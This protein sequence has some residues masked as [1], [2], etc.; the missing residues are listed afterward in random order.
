MLDST[1]VIPTEPWPRA[2]DIECRTARA[3]K[4]ARRRPEGALADPGDRRGES[5]FESLGVGSRERRRNDGVGVLEEVVDDLDLLRARAKAGDRVDGLLGRVLLLDDLRRITSTQ[6]IR[7]VVQNERL[8][9]VDPED[10]EP[11]VHEHTVELEGKRPL[12][13]HAVER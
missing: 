2:D 8:R 5:C 1:V 11:A 10:V 6:R 9:A 4:R 7:L 12:G 13:P 3:G